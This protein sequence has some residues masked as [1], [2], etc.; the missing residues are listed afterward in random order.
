MLISAA[1]LISQSWNLYKSNVTKLSNI[2][3]YYALTSI[4]ITFGLTTM[5][6][7]PALAIPAFI[8]MCLAFIG[9]LYSFI[10]ITLACW[11]IINNQ[12]LNWNS[13][14]TLS[15]KKL[16]PTILVGF[17]TGLIVLGGFIL[18]IIPGFIFAIWYQFAYLIQITSDEKLT[19][20][21]AL[22]ESKSLVVGR[23]WR[24]WYLALAPSVIFG[25]II[26]LIGG[27][28]GAI[29]PGSTTDYTNLA[30]YAAENLASII[31]SAVTAPLIMFPLLLLIKSLKA[32]PVPTVDKI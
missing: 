11:N 31:L 26:G 22:S 27:V 17:V 5:T 10:T 24:T 23:F 4:V 21:K 20:S 29:I 15:Y 30:G 25:L 19:V 8:L 28:I 6:L 9:L 14:Y 1:E 2:L 13:L 18:L 12:A 16:G 32:T 3:L 7:K